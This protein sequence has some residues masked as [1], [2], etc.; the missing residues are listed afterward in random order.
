[1]LAPKAVILSTY[2]D[3]DEVHAALDYAPRSF[4]RERVAH[5]DNLLKQVAREEAGAAE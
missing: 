4:I 1:M 5:R 3:Q 2:Y